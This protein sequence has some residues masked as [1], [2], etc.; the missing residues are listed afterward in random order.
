MA[1]TA[2]KNWSAGETLTAA[3]FN[4]QIRD[5]LL[6]TP[7]H[8]I[9]RKT[10][11]QS[12]TSDTTLA[13]VTSMALTVAANEIWQVLF[14]V[15]YTASTAGDLKLA[16]TFPAGGANGVS[17]MWMSNVP[18]AVVLTIDTSGTGVGLQ[19]LGSGF[20]LACP[21]AVIYTNAGTAGD[22]QLQFAQQTSDGT[23]TTI[24]ANS[25]VW[26]MKLA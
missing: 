18:S 20:T 3:N 7:P 6:A 2:P 22:L 5:N 4:Q 17:A 16:F 19:G 14:S 1:W 10:S 12:K 11:D 9:A 21:I 26:A 23:A 24:K 15:I 13:N 25:T 8:L